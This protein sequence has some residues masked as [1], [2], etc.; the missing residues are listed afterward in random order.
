MRLAIDIKA[1]ALHQTGIAV[2][3]GNLLGLL[4]TPLP[5][6]EITLIGPRAGLDRLA[7]ADRFRFLPLEL[8]SAPRQVR[9]PWYDQV[10]LPRAVARSG[11][12][13]LF[14][15]N[16]DAPIVSPRPVMVTIHDLAYQRFARAYPVAIRQYYGRLARW[17]VRRAPVVLTDSPFA[18]DEL[19]MLDASVRDR[20]EIVPCA[21]EP[22]FFEPCEAT[23]GRADY[24]LYTGGF[25]ARK[26]V[27]A[28][29]RG[30]SAWAAR[31][32][33]GPA[34]LVV[35]GVGR[36]GVGDQGA[37]L[38]AIAGKWVDV[39]LIAP[40]P[41]QDMPRLYRGARAVLYLSRYEGFSLPVLEALAV[42]VPVVAS[43]V[44]FLASGAAPGVELVRDDAGPEAVAD[45]IDRALAAPAVAATERV[46]FART[47]HDSVRPAFATACARL[48]AVANK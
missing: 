16:C 34:T 42:G 32:G 9:L 14:S 10:G 29:I 22:A 30:L 19:A 46:Q 2:Y 43:P 5:D 17:H 35:T 26:N 18:A 28:V 24:F 8:P 40:I 33:G 48:A 44:G 1:L 11:A 36:L 13:A 15:P 27:E 38:S 23:G 21:L 3:L 31:R 12:D 39:R 7:A 37:S 25:D 4:A 47:V 6:I 45:A 20:L 41:R